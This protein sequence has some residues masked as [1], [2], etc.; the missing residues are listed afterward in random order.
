MLAM[1]SHA[2]MLLGDVVS[3]NTECRLIDA[4]S[5]LTPSHGTHVQHVHVVVTSKQYAVLSS[6]NTTSS[7]VYRDYSM[8]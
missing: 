6:S 4:C 5:A 3:T 8:E 1:S 2:Y 7:T